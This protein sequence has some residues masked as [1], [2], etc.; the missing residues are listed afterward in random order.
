M[1]GWSEKSLAVI[2]RVHASLPDDATFEQR[3]A[4]IKAAYPFGERDYWPY[5][6]WLKARRDYLARF[7]TARHKTARQML[8][9]RADIVFPFADG[10][11]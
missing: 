3:K 5:K 1:S 11:A 6:A 7:D 2:G 8:A 10:D 9:G 4:A